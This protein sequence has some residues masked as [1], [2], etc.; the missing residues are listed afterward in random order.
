MT[1]TTLRRHIIRA[2]SI[3]ALYELDATTH[4]LPGVL[5]TYINMDTH[6]EDARV[7]AFQALC[8]FDVERDYNEDELPLDV[9]P[10]APEVRMLHKLI[11]GVVNHRDELDDMIATYAK[12]WPTDQLALIDRNILRVAIYE[13]VYSRAPLKVVIN[14]AVEI[15]KIFG[16]DSAPRFVNG[17]LGTVADYLDAPDDADPDDALELAPDDEK[18]QA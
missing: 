15:A 5:N 10:S 3:L 4:E 18:P 11:K 9:L 13:I 6:T 17:V 12:E 2:A 16:S 8:A 14:E 7:N 1:S